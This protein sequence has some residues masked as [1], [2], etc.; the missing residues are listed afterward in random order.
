MAKDD[1]IE[2]DA[3]QNP[4]DQPPIPPAINNYTECTDFSLNHV[5]QAATSNTMTRYQFILA[6]RQKRAITIEYTTEAKRCNLVAEQICQ[7]LL[8]K[9]LPQPNTNQAANGAQHTSVLIQLKPL[10]GGNIRK[11]EGDMVEHKGEIS[12]H[13]EKKELLTQQSELLTP[14]SGLPSH[15]SDL[16]KAPTTEKPDAPGE[17]D[18]HTD[19]NKPST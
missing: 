14:Q 18:D 5:E 17:E 13:G 16:F 1:K 2:A 11:F 19:K 4:G 6:D 12:F 8:T 9:G 7:Q 15:K 10:D 3:S